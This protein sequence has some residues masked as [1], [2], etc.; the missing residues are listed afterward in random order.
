MS[1]NDRLL[2]AARGEKV[3]KVP[4]WVMRQAGRYLPGTVEFSGCYVASSLNL[5]EC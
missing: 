1:S 4:V 2:Q 5:V 3:D